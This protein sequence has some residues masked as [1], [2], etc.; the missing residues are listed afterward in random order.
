MKRHFN[1]W[2]ILMVLI[3]LMVYAGNVM[4][5]ETVEADQDKKAMVL[6]MGEFAWLDPIKPSEDRMAE[7]MELVKAK[8]GETATASKRFMV[9]DDE[10]TKDVESYLQ[11]EAFM[12]LNNDE[13]HK[14]A[15][16][17]MNDYS[18]RG[19]IT[20]CKFTKRTTG[21]KGYTCLLTLKL[22]VANSRDGANGESVASRSFV[23][24]FKKMIVRNTS[25][26]A[27]DDALQSM[28]QKM[29]DFF[30]NNFSIYG[31]VLKYDGNEVVISCGKDQGIEKGN[32]FQVLNILLAK[33]SQPQTTHIGKI[34]VKELLPDGTSV[35]S[36]SDGKDG[37]IERFKN[38][39]STNWLQ[40]K[41]ILK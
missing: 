3:F 36:I 15:T 38:T 37:I 35:C 34:K 7:L 13:L 39:S 31:T 9:L 11:S 17:L 14:V 2:S 23:S 12:S 27:L 33:G 25:E 6:R 22:T 20:K 21:A 24:D 41:L 16:D 32:E 18:L 10:I 26:A 28:T 29:V 19:E 1:I 40:C 5:Q 4:A 30:A 8:V